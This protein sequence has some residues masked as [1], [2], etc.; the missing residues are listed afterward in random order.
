M[1]FFNNI[2]RNGDLSIWKDKERQMLND[3]SDPTP[4]L[5]GT[6]NTPNPMVILNGTGMA[7]FNSLLQPGSPTASLVYLISPVTFP[8]LRNIANPWNKSR[9]SQILAT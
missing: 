2:P 6:D 7:P 9:F 3:Q 4:Q 5:S 1:R 8:V